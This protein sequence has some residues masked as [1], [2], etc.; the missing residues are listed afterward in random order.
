M[1]KIL[2][3]LI[4]L[5]LPFYAY[6]TSINCQPVVIQSLNFNQ[7]DSN[8]SV[9]NSSVAI[10]KVMCSTAGPIS[11]VLCF[12]PGNMGPGSARQMHN[13]K[14]YVATFNYDLYADLNRTQLIRNGSDLCL[15]TVNATDC[16]QESQCRHTIYGVIQPRQQIASGHYQD[17]VN[18][19]LQVDSPATLPSKIPLTPLQ[20]AIAVNPE[21]LKP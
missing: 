4:A 9:E 10:I 17:A 13:S 1:I 8:N 6:A 2:L 12:S 20:P 19:S 7:Y 14:K 16:S 5:V 15:P 21:I 18:V 11:Y 3:L